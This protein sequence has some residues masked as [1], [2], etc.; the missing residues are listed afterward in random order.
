MKK[1]NRMKKLLFLSFLLA[2]AHVS[3]GQYALDKGRAQFNAGLG[4]SSW[5]LPVY[6]GLDYGVHQD[7]SVGGELSFRTYRERYF[8]SRY[9]HN[10][11]GI[12]GNGNYHF[13]TV[14][15]IPREWDFYA[16]LNLGFYI[17]NSSGDYEGDGSSELGLGAQVGGRYY[18]N[19][20][21][22]INLE[23]G[24]G[25]AFSGGKFGISLKL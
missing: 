2:A 3:F 5:G 23:F 11:I 15:D 17:W 21:F 19:D 8:G 16:G 25:N 12:S 18:F 10:I 1:T 7:I 14:L 24:G 6:V 9:S 13:N 20:K 22:G 4:F